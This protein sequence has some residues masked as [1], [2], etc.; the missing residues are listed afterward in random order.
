M[1]QTL[2]KLINRHTLSKEEAKNA[3]VM[4]GQGEANHAQMAAFVTVFL[5]RSITTDELAGFREAMLSLCAAVDLD[6]YSPVDLVGTGGD[7]KNTFNISTLS[8]IVAAGAGVKIAKH[9]NYAVSSASGSSN[10]LENLGFSF[11]NDITKINQ[12]IDQANIT[13]FHAPLFHP[14]M[15]NVAP[16]RKE[17]GMK[18][19]FNI[20]GPLTNPA[21][22]QKRSVGVYNLE[23]M[24]LYHSLLEQTSE[25]YLIVHSLD[26]YD[27]ISLTGQ[28]KLI[29][30]EFAKIYEPSDLG[31]P[32]LHP[33]ELFGGNTVEEAA[34]VFKK[35]LSGEGNKSQ[36]AV[37]AANA[38]TAIWV[39][40]P[41][42][43]LKEAIHLAK[44]SL[45]SGKAYACFEKLLSI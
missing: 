37:V 22:L 30:N 8:S 36:N 39:D 31:L 17:L 32:K 33:D 16:V 4:M 28:F 25:R 27:E 45:E 9:G 1:K 3:F 24:R 35:I 15:K 44:E 21:H 40:N 11:S 14:A 42:I 19:F 6:K 34:Q 29:S 26:G 13:F 18:T 10:V 23:I 43:D 41:G 38:G 20:L 7:S 5:M 2:Q 12:Q